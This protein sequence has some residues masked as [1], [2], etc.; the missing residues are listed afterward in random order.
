M[1][2]PAFCSQ[3]S[4]KSSVLPWAL[5]TSGSAGSTK[6]MCKSVSVCVYSQSVLPLMW[7]LSY[8]SSF[9]GCSTTTGATSSSPLS[10]PVYRGELP[11]SRW[12][13]SPSSVPSCRWGGRAGKAALWPRSS[14]FWVWSS[15]H[16]LVPMKLVSWGLS[17]FICKVGLTP[18][19]SW[20]HYEIHEVT[21]MN[22]I[23]LV[24]VAFPQG[25][26]PK[27]HLPWA[28]LT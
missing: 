3:A 25:S 11:R 7:R 19:I 14:E 17:V 2:T 21:Y 26:L 8:L 28:L 9:S 27:S 10:W 23:P 5:A 24:S 20:V 15:S 13:M 4:L 1:L 6:A 18:P 12:R 22:C 16:L